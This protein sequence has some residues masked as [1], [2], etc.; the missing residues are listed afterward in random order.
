MKLSDFILMNENEKRI[1][2]LHSGV[3]VAKRA[4]EEYCIFLFQLDGF[5]VE[6][7]CSLADK[8]VHEYRAYTEVGKLTPYLDSIQLDGFL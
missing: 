4:N 5:Y 6:V 2:V 3:L 7:F 8:S 1:I